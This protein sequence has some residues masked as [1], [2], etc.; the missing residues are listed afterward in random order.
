MAKNTSA[1]NYH[2]L[3]LLKNHSKA[4]KTKDVQLKK[5]TGEPIGEAVTS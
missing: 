2:S 1:K 3:K 5:V 4:E